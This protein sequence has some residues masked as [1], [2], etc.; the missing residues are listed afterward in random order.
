MHM[1]FNALTPVGSAAAHARTGHATIVATC[2]GSGLRTHFAHMAY[3]YANALHA[4]PIKWT[5]SRWAG[6]HA[7]QHKWASSTRTQLYAT[8]V[9]TECARVCVQMCP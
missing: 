1:L 3:L 5:P 4:F 9:H 2:T 8:Q 6:V 7:H